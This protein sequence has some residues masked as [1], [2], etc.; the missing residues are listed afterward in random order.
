MSQIESKVKPNQR[1]NA[2]SSRLLMNEIVYSKKLEVPDT[3]KVGKKAG[4]KAGPRPNGSSNAF[5]KY[6][7]LRLKN[8]RKLLMKLKPSS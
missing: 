3:G 7:M 1:P 6:L 4:K 8:D 2:L 5:T